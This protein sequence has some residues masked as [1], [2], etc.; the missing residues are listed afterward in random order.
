[1]TLNDRDA[2]GS[3]GPAAVR[4]RARCAGP[5]RGSAECPAGSEGSPRPRSGCTPLFLNAEPSSTGVTAI[6]SV[7]LRSARRIISGVTASSSMRYVSSSS[8][9]SATASISW[10]WYS[11]ACSL[12]SGG[13]SCSSNCIPSSSSQ[14]FARISMTSTTPRKFSSWPIGR[15]HRH[16][17]GAEPVDDRLH[18]GEEVRARA[19]HLVLMNAI[20]GTTVVG[21]APDCLGLR[22]DACDRVEDRDRAVEH[23]Y[24]STSTVKST[25]GRID[26]VDAV[27]LPER[28]RS[29]RRIV[30]VSAPAP[31]P[32]SPSSAPLVDL[33]HPVR[34]TGVVEDPLGRRRLARVD[35]GHDPDVADALQRNPTAGS[36]SRRHFALPYQR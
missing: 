17:L 16:R 15:L 32:S 24:S 8:S 27:V 26:N 36:L 3:S 7:A 12:S 21:L 4:A 30:D 9:C 2:K 20:R 5:A 13:I 18:G 33:A 11:C 1:M 19:V 29:R 35:V 6:S 22:L 10:W 34:S 14:T 25:P 28:R 23:A 31:A